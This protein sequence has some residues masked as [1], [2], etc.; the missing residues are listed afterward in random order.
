MAAML[1]LLLAAAALA[2]PSADKLTI[3][4]ED[5]SVIGWNDACSVAVT[6]RAYPRLGDAIAGDP[7]M[8]RVGTITLRPGEE[9]P[10]RLWTLE[11]DGQLSWDGPAFRKAEQELR[12][13]GWSRPG[14]SETISAGPIG[15]QPG[16]AETLLSTSTLRL[17]RKPHW[18]PSGWRW[19]A[20]HYNP[21]STCAL[22]VFETGE[23]GINHRFLLARIHDP[24][25]RIDRARAHTENARLLL[26]AGELRRAAAEA[27]NGARM[28]PELAITRY[29]HAALL[30]LTGRPDEAMKELSEAVRL[31]PDYREKARLDRDFSELRPRQDFARLTGGR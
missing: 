18:P 19:S 11:L 13:A 23:G 1:P 2:A 22:L 29:H 31:E 10:E 8:T 5:W 4:R 21:L 7:V 28:A 17:R 9:Q 12:K 20:A 16:L 24:R 6:R 30:A 15:S 26:D 25:A 27:E 14:Y 3:A